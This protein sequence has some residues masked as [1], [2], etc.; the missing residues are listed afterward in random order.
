M[1]LR[2]Q[3]ASER[4]G[5]SVATELSAPSITVCASCGEEVA[6]SDPRCV[7]CG[8]NLSS[9]LATTKKPRRQEHQGSFS[10]DT[11]GSFIRGAP[12]I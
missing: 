8:T 1:K 5:D 11:P 12:N 2:R 6:D 10:E 9:P 7:Y 4:K 3:K